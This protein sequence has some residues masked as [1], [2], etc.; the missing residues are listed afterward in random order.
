MRAVLPGKPPS[1]LQGLATGLWDTTHFTVSLLVCLYSMGMDGNGL[2]ELPTS[3]LHHRK[4]LHHPQRSQ[5]RG[6]DHLR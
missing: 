5:Y 2:T 3:G 4:C 6:P 1:R